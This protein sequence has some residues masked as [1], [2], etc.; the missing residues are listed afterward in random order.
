MFSQKAGIVVVCV[1]Q[2]ECL[3][4]GDM[5]LGI[6]GGVFSAFCSGDTDTAFRKS[7][8]EFSP[9]LFAQFITVAQEQR[10]LGQ[11]PGFMHSPEQICGN[12][13]FA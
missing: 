5:D 4:S 2:A 3:I 9:C 10:G 6:L 1:V 7:F 8:G 13:G 12:H 11:P